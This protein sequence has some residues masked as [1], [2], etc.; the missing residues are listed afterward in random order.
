M[1]CQVLPKLVLLYTEE[2]LR[3]INDYQGNARETN[4]FV[5]ILGQDYTL[6]SLRVGYCTGS[7][8]IIRTGQSSAVLS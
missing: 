3:G 4:E 5:R 7:I 6:W 1:F 2:T 8:I